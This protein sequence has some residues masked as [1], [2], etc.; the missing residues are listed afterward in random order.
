MQRGFPMAKFRVAAFEGP[1]NVTEQKLGL[2]FERPIEVWWAGNIPGS[3]S[4]G[5]GRRA[6]T[7]EAAIFYG[8]AGK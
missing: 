7:S 4:S 1:A 6:W 5:D 2:S 3:T 8:K